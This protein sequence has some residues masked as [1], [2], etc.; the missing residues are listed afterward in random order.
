M[1][2]VY[3]LFSFRLDLDRFKVIFKERVKQYEHNEFTTV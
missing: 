3:T 2:N 1:K